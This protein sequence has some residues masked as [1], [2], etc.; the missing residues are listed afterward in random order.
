MG[1]T[2]ST[3]TLTLIRVDKVVPKKMNSKIDSAVGGIKKTAGNATGN[4]KMEAEGMAQSTKGEV[5]YYMQ[6][7]CQQV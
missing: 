3:T 2:S 4:K 5:N 1:Q 7:V 6:N